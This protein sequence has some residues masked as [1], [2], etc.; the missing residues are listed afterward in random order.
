MAPNFTISPLISNAPFPP[1]PG[2]MNSI[3]PVRSMLPSIVLR[4]Y[5]A[6]DH[7]ES[8]KWALFA[9]SERGKAAKDPGSAKG[10]KVSASAR[11]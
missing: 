2:G 7:T 9:C 5:V 3:N 1:S 8:G 4:G 11:V 6:A 10:A